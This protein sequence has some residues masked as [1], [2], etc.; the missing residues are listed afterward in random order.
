MN[1]LQRCQRTLNQHGVRYSHSVHS[2]A[3]TARGLASAEC[4]PVHG[5]AKVVVYF[6]SN[7][8]G[9][10]VLPGDCIVDFT[11]VRRLLGLTEIRLAEETDLLGLFPDCELGAMPP[12]G[13]LIEMPVLVDERLLAEEFIAFNAGTHRDVIH[14]STGD[15]RT[16]VNPLVAAFALPEPVTMGR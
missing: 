3:F 9:L 2:P 11:E 4:M 5:V 6:G 10:L 8:Y 13:N 14:M 7:G 15:F 16:I 12:F 1:I